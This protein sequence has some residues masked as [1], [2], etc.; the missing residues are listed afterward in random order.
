MIPALPDNGTKIP[1]N[2]TR[3]LEYQIVEGDWRPELEKKVN[4]WI[5]KGWEPIGGVS[6]TSQSIVWTQAM[7]KR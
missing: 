4:Y 1:V 7:I 3:K 5:S 6:T 2:E